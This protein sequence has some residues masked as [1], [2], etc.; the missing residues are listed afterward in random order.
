MLVHWLFPG[1][2]FGFWQLKQT[3]QVQQ[4]KPSLDTDTV[5]GNG[6]FVRSSY[7]LPRKEKRGNPGSN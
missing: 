2:Y 1:N 6:I 7:R 4:N 5:F 3:K